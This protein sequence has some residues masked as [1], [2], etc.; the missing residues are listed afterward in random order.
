LSG[1]LD[2]LQVKQVDVL[3]FF[4]VGT[5]GGTDLDLPMEQYIYKRKRGGIYIINLKRSCKLLLAPR[6]IVALENLANVNVPPP[7][8]PGQVSCAEV[9]GAPGTTPIAGC[10]APGTFP[11]QVQ[12]AFWEPGLLGV[13]PKADHQ[14]LTEVFN[15]CLPPL[16]GDPPLH[17]VDVAMLCHNE[18]IHSGCDAREDVLH[19]R[20]FS[21][22]PPWEIMP[23][24]YFCRD[25]EDIG[26]EAQGCCLANEEFQSG[27]TALAPEFTA[28]PPEVAAWSDSARGPSVLWCGS[29]LRPGALGSAAPAARAP[30]WDG[31]EQPLG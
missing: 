24:F 20:G 14:P 22:E 5:S 6:A 4:T 26:K 27:R 19:M 28:V 31:S 8:N 1:A 11:D 30:G 9:A 7:R 25:P 16:C 12:A 29:L 18:D 3:K 2:V 23:D 21:C 15:L 17:H 10:P 13:L